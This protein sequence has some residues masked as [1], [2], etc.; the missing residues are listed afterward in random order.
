MLEEQRRAWLG[1]PQLRQL[2]REW[3]LRIQAQL[4]SV[5][6]ATI[7]I[8]CGIGA[9]KEEYPS[10][11]AT[12]IVQTA[13]TDSVL[14]AERLPLKDGSVANIVMIDVLHHLPRPMSFLAEAERV[15]L[16]G[17]RL[18][19]VEPYCSPFSLVVYSLFH[20]ER[21]D[22]AVDPFSAEAMATD[23]PFDSNQAVPTL[24][25][26]RRLR[27]LE[28]RYPRLTVIHRDRFALFLY[29]MSGGFSRRPLLPST[30]WRLGHVVE[31]VLRPLSPLLAFRCIV[32]LEKA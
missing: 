32:A 3:F 6:G 26:W 11:I 17:G 13:W 9:L 20:H 14:D 4:S 7:E 31:R 16:P 25:F 5:P 19:L 27:D 22:I 23:V 29:P 12:D 15:L 10:V 21:T 24:L 1:R 18:V 28:E 2:Y 8:G 30:L